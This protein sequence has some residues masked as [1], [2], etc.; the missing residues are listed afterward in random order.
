M[1]TSLIS[2]LGKKVPFRQISSTRR[3]LSRGKWGNKH[4]FTLSL[5]REWGCTEKSLNQSVSWSVFL[6]GKNQLK[7]NSKRETD[8]DFTQKALL[9]E[10]PSPCAEGK[11][12]IRVC[13]GMAEKRWKSVWLQSLRSPPP[14][15]DPVSWS[16]GCPRTAQRAKAMVRV[17]AWRR[18]QSGFH[19][20]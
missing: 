5:I 6:S 19:K 16:A 11:W 1:T 17:L 10:T 20:L 13:A 14:V 18:G 2:A 7:Q 15:F 12:N 9:V 3:N 8:R 4:I